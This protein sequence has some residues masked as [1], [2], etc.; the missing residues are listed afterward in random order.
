VI[1]DLD[2]Y[3]TAKI[4]LDNHGER[5]E[6]EADRAADRMHERGDAVGEAVWMR[7]KGCR[8]A[9]CA[10]RRPRQASRFIEGFGAASN[11]RA[12]RTLCDSRDAPASA[13]TSAS[14]ARASTW[15][16]LYVTISVDMC[17]VDIR[18]AFAGRNHEMPIEDLNVQCV[19]RLDVVRRR[20]AVILTVPRDGHIHV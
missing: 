15:F 2:I 14:Q 9:S 18:D 1:S 6:A 7:V 5:A 19:A 3:R 11:E 17:W 12:Q 8:S 20:D 10:E 13:I 16:N 4:V